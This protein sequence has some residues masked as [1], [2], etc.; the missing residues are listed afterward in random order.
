[1][2]FKIIPPNIILKWLQQNLQNPQKALHHKRQIDH[3]IPK[4]KGGSGT[5]ANG[6]VL[7]RDCNRTK[8]DN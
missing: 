3:K 6:Q 4:S 1:M 8:S 5:E 7:C 2:V